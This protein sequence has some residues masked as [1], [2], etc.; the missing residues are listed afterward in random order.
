MCTHRQMGRRPRGFNLL[1]L[2]VTIGIF[3]LLMFW[4]VPS[5]GVWIKNAR[6]RSVAE[7]LQNDL[8]VAQAAALLQDRSVSLLLVDGSPEASNVSATVSSSS[9]RWL[10]RRV[11]DPLT[12]SDFLRGFSNKSGAGD[13]NVT[14][15]SGA[16]GEVRFNA[17]GRVVAAAPVG[18]DIASTQAGDSNLR[19]LRV[20]V[21]P[22]GNVRMCDPDGR[23]NAN[24]SRRC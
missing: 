9:A 13:V 20:L 2:M 16:T 18:F 24:D 23:L 3:S 5:F 17:L 8:R 10:V 12:A 22:G 15:I 19:P 14:P 7:A 21:S 11:A 6:I 4:A 1:E